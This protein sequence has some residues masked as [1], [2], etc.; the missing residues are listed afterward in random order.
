MG[1]VHEVKGK[2][3]QQGIVDLARTLGWRVA[4]FRSVPVKYPSQPLR[5]MTPVQADGKGFP[6]LILVR[7]RV[8]AVEIKGDGDSLKP[9]QEA[10]LTAFRIAGIQAYVW[11]PGEWGDGGVI[12]TELQRR[13]RRFPS[14]ETFEPE[15]LDAF[16]E[17][18]TTPVRR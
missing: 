4:H 11:G 17:R 3:L 7:E 9:E 14:V 8:V 16:I 1:V 5:W 10:W 2:E 13:D 6:D 18:M 12:E 15:P